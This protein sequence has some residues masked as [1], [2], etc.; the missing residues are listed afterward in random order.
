[1]NKDI[2]KVL[3]N[4]AK[5]ENHLA[6]AARKSLNNAGER[7]RQ[8]TIPRAPIDTGKLRLSFY[9]ANGGQDNYPV[10]E[11]GSMG[12]VDRKNGFH[13]AIIQHE[14]AEFEHHNGGEF[15]YLERTVNDEKPSLVS[16]LN[17]DIK[18]QMKKFKAI[19]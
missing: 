2:Q 13:Y 16:R 11:V 18:I 10:V 8:K 19:K 17:R 3:K 7:L 1:M 6:D 15:K 12:A 4:L 5:L 9:I 14:T